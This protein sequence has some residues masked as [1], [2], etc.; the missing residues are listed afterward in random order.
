[1]W[2]L[3]LWLPLLWLP[4]LLW[5][6]PPPPPPPPPFLASAGEAASTATIQA[7]TRERLVKSAFI[8]QSPKNKGFVCRVKRPVRSLIRPVIGLLQNRQEFLGGRPPEM[9]KRSRNR[10][11]WLKNASGKGM[12]FLRA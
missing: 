5:F 12:G 11:V 4:P 1:M 2:L 3:L 10:S 7:R 8:F 9:R 6:P